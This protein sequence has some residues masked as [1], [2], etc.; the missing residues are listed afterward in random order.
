LEFINFSENKLKIIEP[1]ILDGLNNLKYVN[2]SKNPNFDKCYSVYDVYKPNATLKEV[3]DQLLEKYGSSLD[4]LKNMNE[5]MKS[6]TILK[7]QLLDVSDSWYYAHEK[8]KSENNCLMQEIDELRESDEQLKLE[9]ANLKSVQPQTDLAIELKAYIQ[10]ESTKDFK[11]I[12]NDH[13]IPVHKFLLA[14]RSPTLAELFQ[15]K[16]EAENLKLIDISVE[17]FEKILEYLYTDELPCEDGTNFLHIFSAAGKMKIERL[18]KYAAPK[19]LD[20][21]SQDN[22]LNIF[23][24]SANFGLNELKENAFEKVKNKYKEINFDDKLKENS[25]DVI[26]II[27]KF[28]KKEEALKDFEE[29]L[30]KLSIKY[31]AEDLNYNTDSQ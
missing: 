26:K 24:I 30:R 12:I 8:L 16:P 15:N 7:N 13:E 14:V 19:I 20:Q 27:R 4:Q 21:V 22:A 3:K 5:L 29:E 31:S 18:V 9:N 10:D 23:C 6:N 28:K 11:I 2:F 17:I 25:D 1:N